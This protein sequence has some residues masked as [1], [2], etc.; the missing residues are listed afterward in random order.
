[1]AYQ[2]KRHTEPEVYRERIL[3][4]GHPPPTGQSCRIWVPDTGEEDGYFLAL[5]QQ[6]TEELTRAFFFSTTVG[7]ERYRET[8]ERIL[9]A[10]K[11]NAIELT[12]VFGT[13]V[14]HYAD[15]P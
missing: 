15:W 2:F 14:V 12:G 5:K 11:L 4:I 6:I 8:A 7:E 1:M 9:K 3:R 13:G 10:Y